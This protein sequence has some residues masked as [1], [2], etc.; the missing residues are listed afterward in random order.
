MKKLFA[1]AAALVFVGSLAAADLLFVTLDPSDPTPITSATVTQGDT[2]NLYVWVTTDSTLRGFSIPFAFKSPTPSVMWESDDADSS[3]LYAPFNG[4]LYAVLKHAWNGDVAEFFFGGL[5]LFGQN[6]QPPGTYLV[7]RAEIVVDPNFTGDVL[8]DTCVYLNNAPMY[9]NYGTG[10][11]VTVNPDW[12]PVTFTV[13]AA[14]PPV[15]TLHVAD[16][17]EMATINIPTG[18]QHE[19]WF[20][21]PGTRGPSVHLVIHNITAAGDLSVAVYNTAYANTIGS[22]NKYWYLDFT[23]TAD[24]YDLDFYYLDT[25]VPAGLD[26]TQF[27]AWY[28]DHSV[29]QWVDMGGTPDAVNNIVSGV[30]TTHLSEWTLGPPGVTAVEEGNQIPRVFFLNQ[31]APNPFRGR[32]TIAFGLPKAADVSLV[33]YN[34]AGQKVRT[35]VS[36]HKEAGTYTVTWDGRN[37]AGQP[38]AAGAYFYKFQAGEYQSLKKMLLLK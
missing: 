13:Q 10:S 28:L 16:Y 19:I 9:L 21:E 15:D 3:E 18:P 2:F 33:V 14:G 27:H 36:G 38:V 25:D 30:S 26:E 34:A 7:G 22:I 35:L 8:L 5:D 20:M 17:G 37:D 1:V 29:P 4:W 12:S 24:S 23:G 11:N 32:T 6:I 31:N